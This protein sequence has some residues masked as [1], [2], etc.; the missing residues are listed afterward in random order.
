[1]AWHALAIIHL[2]CVKVKESVVERRRELTIESAN[3]LRNWEGIRNNGGNDLKYRRDKA[4]KEM[5][6]RMKERREQ[7]LPRDETCADAEEPRP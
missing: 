2:N 3:K 6:L 7:F 5:S 4:K 1:L